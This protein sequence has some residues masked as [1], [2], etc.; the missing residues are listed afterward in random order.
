[1][2]CTGP[3]S[4]S[5]AL[6]TGTNKYS[7][8]MRA[9]PSPGWRGVASSMSVWAT[10]SKAD[11][12][13]APASGSKAPNT[14]PSCGKSKAAS[15]L[16]SPPPPVS[17]QREGTRTDDGGR[18]SEKSPP[19]GCHDDDDAVSS[20]SAANLL[21]SPVYLCARRGPFTPQAPR[22]NPH[23]HPPWSI[24]PERARRQTGP[25]KPRPVPSLA[26]LLPTPS[27]SGRGG[28]WLVS[29]LFPRADLKGYHPPAGPGGVGAL[30]WLFCLTDCLSTST[31]LCF[32]LYLHLPPC[33]RPR[34][35]V[36][37]REPFLI[38]RV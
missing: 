24:F 19:P 26:H 16:Q 9:R 13:S 30:A 17:L 37:S 14:L 10:C 27:L 7:C 34:R 2:Y 11:L 29:L 33:P 6:T 8:A 28:R 4:T 5:L 23:P 18:G 1:M 12:L 3:R 38:I 36:D 21:C 15:A 20:R 32:C 22:P 31:Y 25:W 35:L